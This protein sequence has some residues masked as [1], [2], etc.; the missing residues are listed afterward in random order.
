MAL[1]LSWLTSFIVTAS[2]V[3]ATVTNRKCRCTLFTHFSVV[4]LFYQTGEKQND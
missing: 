4:T 3:L 1:K 2:C